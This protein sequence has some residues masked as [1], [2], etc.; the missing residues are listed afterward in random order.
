M[1]KKNDCMHSAIPYCLT[2][3]EEFDRKYMR[4]TSTISHPRH[5]VYKCCFH[6]CLRIGVDKEERDHQE[7]SSEHSLC[8]NNL[9]Q[10]YYSPGTFSSRLMHAEPKRVPDYGFRRQRQK[11]QLGTV[12]FLL[13]DLKLLQVKEDTVLGGKHINNDK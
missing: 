5:V 11:Q 8:L 1:S 2:D 10:G 4:V 6:F 9:H 3:K 13:L 12:T 7:E